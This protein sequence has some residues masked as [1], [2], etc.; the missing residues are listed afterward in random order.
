MLESVG[1]VVM[2]GTAARATAVDQARQY[3]KDRFR[4]KW[5]DLYSAQKKEA[6]HVRRISGNLLERAVYV[7][8]NRERLGGGRPGSSSGRA[9]PKIPT[10]IPLCW[11]GIGTL[12]ISSDTSNPSGV[13]MTSS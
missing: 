5:R 11:S 8:A 2:T 13:R 7:Y 6:K 9:S 4:P 10:G 12:L 1:L 3:V